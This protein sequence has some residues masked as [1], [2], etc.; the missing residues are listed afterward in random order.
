MRICPSYY[1]AGGQRREKWCRAAAGAAESL[2]E[3]SPQSPTRREGAQTPCPTATPG[4]TPRPV[5][6]KDRDLRFLLFASSDSSCFLFRLFFWPRSQGPRS[7]P[8]CP[9]SWDGASPVLLDRL[10]SLAAC[11]SVGLGG[12]LQ[13]SGPG[14]LGSSASLSECR[15]RLLRS[16]E[17]ASRWRLRAAFM[18]MHLVPVRISFLS[19]AGQRGHPAWDQ[20]HLLLSLLHLQHSSSAKAAM[21]RSQN[22]WVSIPAPPTFK[23]RGANF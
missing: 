4:L 15:D 21:N 23:K 1:A 17:G 22:A 3:S 11:C 13:A 2:G 16:M 8:P 19:A 10:S 7:S 9:T 14:G 12:R 5:T 18:E 20:G 6:S